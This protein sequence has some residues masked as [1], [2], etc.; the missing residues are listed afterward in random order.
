MNK[1][2]GAGL[3]AVVGMISA[4]AA[5][6]PSETTELAGKSDELRIGDRTSCDLLRCRAGFRCEEQAG[7]A[8][9]APIGKRVCETDSDCRLV[10]N[11]CGGCNCLALGVGQTA[12]KC[13]GDEVACLVA[14]CLGQEAF[15]DN[16]RCS[17]EQGP[18]F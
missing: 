5:D 14:P 15:C 9:C 17:A 11:Y 7:I 10:D 16:G 6:G 2:F 1:T 18:S 8:F 4:C 13:T 3:Y 12:P